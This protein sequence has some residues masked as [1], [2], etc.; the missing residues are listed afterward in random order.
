MDIYIGQVNR[1]NKVL[2]VISYEALNIFGNKLV[3][4]SD[5][6]HLQNIINSSGRTFW[7]GKYKDYK[8]DFVFVPNEQLSDKVSKLNKVSMDEWK[9][10]VKMSINKCGRYSI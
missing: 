9:D 7:G 1:I 2:Q 4:I 5:R 10:I 6:T 8:N 3:D